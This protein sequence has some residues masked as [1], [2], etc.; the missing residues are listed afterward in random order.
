MADAG[1]HTNMANTYILASC[2]LERSCSNSRST[3][4][5][6]HPL[7][8]WSLQ[9]VCFNSS[10]IMWSL[11]AIFCISLYTKTH[12]HILNHESQVC[13]L[14]KKKNTV[15]LHYSSRVCVYDMGQWFPAFFVWC[16]PAA[17]SDEHNVPTC[18]V[19]YLFWPV[20]IYFELHGIQHYW[21]F[22]SGCYYNY[23]VQ[24]N[25]NII[26]YHFSS[27]WSVL[28]SLEVF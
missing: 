9:Y 14:W 17:L 22:M 25:I 6:T 3:H 27:A 10:L 16:T 2:E 12:L 23:L 8:I 11:Q 26:A 7:Y 13:I 28:L 1:I 5:E 20:W 19:P 15:W 18:H 21:F 4:S 24:L